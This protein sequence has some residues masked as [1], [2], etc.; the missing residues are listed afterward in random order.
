MKRLHK[1]MTVKEYALK[2]RVSKS[3]VYYYIKKG[4]IPS[5][6][7]GFQKFVEDQKPNYHQLGKKG[8]IK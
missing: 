2:Y 1:A 3:S 8:R 7:R 5:E 6:R 4:L